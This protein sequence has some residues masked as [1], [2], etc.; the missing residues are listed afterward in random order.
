MVQAPGWEGL[1]GTNT[2]A[3]LAK[4]VSYKDKHVLR[5]LRDQHQQNFLGQ[6][7]RNFSQSVK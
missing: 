3:Y 2:P 1:A 4:F 6:S 5:V 7:C